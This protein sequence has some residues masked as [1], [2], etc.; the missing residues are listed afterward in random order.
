MTVIGNC[1]VR[2]G[3]PLYWDEKGRRGNINA[4]GRCGG[5]RQLGRSKH[6]WK[7]LKLFSRKLDVGGVG[8]LQLAG[9][10]DHDNDVCCR[11]NCGEFLNS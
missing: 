3:E 10:C 11:K 6:R 2:V 9:S 5:Q 8:W 4:G 1:D 7:I